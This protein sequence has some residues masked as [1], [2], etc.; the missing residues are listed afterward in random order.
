M[1]NAGGSRLV[2]GLEDGPEWCEKCEE[3][4]PC[5]TCTYM[6]CPAGCGR[7]VPSADL[8]SAVQHGLAHADSRFCWGSPGCEV[9]A[10]FRKTALGKLKPK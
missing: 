9:L 8:A 4:R 10:A 3:Y 6:L 2:F 5:S 1:S 7:P